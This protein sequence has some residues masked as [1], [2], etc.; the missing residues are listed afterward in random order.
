M[1]SSDY[2]RRFIAEFIQLKNHYEGL[3]AML[4][5]WDFDEL[6]FTP[7]CPRDTYDVQFAAMQRYLGILEV[8]ANMENIDIY[9]DETAN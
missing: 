3:K 9:Y 6:N 7:T 2:K 1:V 8:R 4:R 5:K